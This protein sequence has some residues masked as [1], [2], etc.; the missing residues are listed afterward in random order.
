M[1]DKPY[2]LESNLEDN[3]TRDCSTVCATQLPFKEDQT[4]ACVDN[5]KFMHNGTNVRKN[6][7][8]FGKKQHSNGLEMV[9]LA[10][11]PDINTF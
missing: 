7:T 4:D 6:R 11:K 10:E 5:A 9:V 2:Q 3:Q 1:R 8:L